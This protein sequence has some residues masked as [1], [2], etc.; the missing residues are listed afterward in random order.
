MKLPKC[1]ELVVKPYDTYA[2]C[3][4]I[5]IVGKVSVKKCMWFHFKV[6]QQQ[7]L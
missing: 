6:M 4:I 3:G 2:A 7:T 5:G 1:V